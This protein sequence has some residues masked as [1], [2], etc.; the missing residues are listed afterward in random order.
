[1]PCC[2][3]ILATSL[4]ECMTLA[5]LPLQPA[6]YHAFSEEV[7]FLETQFG[8]LNGSAYVMGD[9]LHGLQWHIYAAG[10]P[11]RQTRCSRQA[12]ASI[13]VCMTH[14]CPTKV[15]AD[16]PCTQH[17]VSGRGPS[18]DRGPCSCCA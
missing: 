15:S 17:V 11:E 6:P 4:K 1:M 2:Q 13:E 16:W 8:Q 7:A 5:L 10:G 12:Q 18:S 14:L 3:A 9:A